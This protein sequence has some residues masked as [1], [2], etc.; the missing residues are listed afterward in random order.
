MQ[1]S[2]VPVHVM[3]WEA[4]S[5]NQQRKNTCAKAGVFGEVTFG[6]IDAVGSS[7]SADGAENAKKFGIGGEIGA[8]Q[9]DAVL[10]TLGDAGTLQLIIFVTRLAGEGEYRLKEIE[11]ILN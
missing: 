1:F 4:H 3:H 11:K 5:V 7:G 6:A 9:G 10:M 8:L 2:A